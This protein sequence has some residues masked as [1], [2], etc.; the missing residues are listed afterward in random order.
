ML[1]ELQ[2]RNTELIAQNNQLKLENDQLRKQSKIRVFIFFVSFSLIGQD[3][4]R[5]EDNGAEVAGTSRELW[6]AVEI[7]SLVVKKAKMGKR[8]P[9]EQ[10]LEITI[11]YIVVWDPANGGTPAPPNPLAENLFAKKKP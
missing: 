1:E 3:R 11:V 4:P 2:E 9:Y 8:C 6:G 5:A 7:C 10:K